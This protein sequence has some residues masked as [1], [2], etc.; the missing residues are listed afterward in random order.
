MY[1][2]VVMQGRALGGAD[3]GEVKRNFIRVTG[4]PARVA[5][6]LFGGMPQVVKRKML[7]KDAERIAA[8]LRAIGAA[9]TVERELAEGEEAGDEINVATPLMNGPPTVVPG[10]EPTTQAPAT[11]SPFARALGNVREHWKPIVGVVVL[12][13][14]AIGLAPFADDLLSH[15]RRA[16]APAATVAAKPAANADVAESAP[17]PNATLIHG[18]WRCTDQ[19]TG[20]STYWSY[21]ADGSL[22]YHGDVLRD[23]PAPPSPNAPAPTGWKIEARRLVQTYAQRAPVSYSL[24]NLTLTRLRYTDDRLLEV[25]CRRP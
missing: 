15:L 8:T 13:A 6:E 19:R 17:M 9:A 18:P 24:T 4:L 22:V 3:L 23:K 14:A 11:R 20:E 2:R 1:Y 16:P 10:S 5:E 7:Q 25:E 12:I 21:N